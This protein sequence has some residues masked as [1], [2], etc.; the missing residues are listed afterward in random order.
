MVAPSRV[1]PVLLGQVAKPPMPAYSPALVQPPRS[2]SG[3]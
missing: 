2:R 1:V 3:A